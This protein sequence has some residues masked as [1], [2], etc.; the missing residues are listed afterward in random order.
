MEFSH[1]NLPPDIKIDDP[2]RFIDYNEPGI[3]SFSDADDDEVN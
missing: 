2:L 3:I 1:Y